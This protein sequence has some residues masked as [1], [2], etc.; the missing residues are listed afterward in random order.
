MNSDLLSLPEEARRVGVSVR[1]AQRL[2]SEGLVEVV[3]VG[4]FRG[5]KR[6]ALDAFVGIDRRKR[7][8]QVIG[9]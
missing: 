8:R 6:G 5:V 9:G 4:R 3:R 1:T 7:R 2:A